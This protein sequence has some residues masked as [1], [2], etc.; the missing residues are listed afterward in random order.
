MDTTKTQRIQQPKRNNPHS[1]IMLH[2]RQIISSSLLY[3]LL[4]FSGGFL[5]GCIRVPFLEPLLG[6]RTAQLLEMP[7]MAMVIWRSARVVVRRMSFRPKGQKQRLGSM[8]VEI[9]SDCRLLMG[10]LALA[11]FVALEVGLYSWVNRAEQKG[12]KE[13]VFERDYV[14][15]SVFFGLLVGFAVLPAVVG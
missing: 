8:A 4:V 7:V 15:G 2:A 14:A 9:D 12:W 1:H 5:C 3:T 6:Q 10:L 13:W 11:W